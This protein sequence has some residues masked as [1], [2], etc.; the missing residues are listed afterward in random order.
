MDA[1][2][3]ELSRDPAQRR[4]RWIAVMGVTA[5][6]AAGVAAG[7]LG[8]W[9]RAGCDPSAMLGDLWTSER[10]AAVR[11][12][13]LQGGATYAHDSWER[14]ERHLDRRVGEWKEAYSVACGNAKER[15]AAGDRAFVAQTDCLER[16]RAEIANIVRLLETGEADIVEHGVKM[17]LGIGSP[18]ECGQVERLLDGTDA[19]LADESTR[20]A[21][22]E[23]R[24]DISKARALRQAG[25]LAAAQRLTESALDRARSLGLPRLIAEALVNRADVAGAVSDHELAVA[26]AGEAYGLAIEHGYDAVAFSAAHQLAYTLGAALQQIGEATIYLHTA[27]AL[28][29]RPG[30]SSKE[31]AEA[32]QVSG[33]VAFAAGDFEACAQDY[34]RAYERESELHG[35]NHPDAAVPLGN[36]AVCQGAL[37]RLEESL[38]SLRRVVEIEQ[39][40]FGPHHP[41]L[42]LSEGRLGNALA[43]MGRF[44]EALETHRRALRIAEEAYGPTD[45]ATQT[46][47][48]SLGATLMYMGRY[49]EALEHFERAVELDRVGEDEPRHFVTLRQNLALAYVELGRLEEAETLLR[50]MLEVCDRTDPQ[51]PFFVH[52]RLTLAATLIEREKYEEARDVTEA[53]LVV[54]EAKTPDDAAA[55][56]TALANLGRSQLELGDIEA[57]RKSLEAAA[58]LLD[59]RLPPQLVG[60][61]RLELARVLAKQGELEAA[62]RQGELAEAVLVES[63][64]SGAKLLE[65]L[66]A[67]KRTLK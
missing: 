21:A 15:G 52:V 17:T 2:L 16:R 4:R 58:D 5:V 60:A 35:E 27:K 39:S 43:R 59:D 13:Y 29:R 47:W 62:R 34:Y 67:L 26:L 65:K 28:A 41:V 11:R 61:V 32:L 49:Q 54:I 64:A 19:E 22:L 36:A 44:E 24:T 57:A 56:T 46:A 9:E 7:R 50:E 14:I 6:V 45:R 37:G 53:A 25:R 51:S 20:Q 38:V 42:A 40:A 10:K 30:H 55:R 8:V 33:S 3:E 12:D 1:L 66:T 48:M 63:G 23:I 18:T 31:E